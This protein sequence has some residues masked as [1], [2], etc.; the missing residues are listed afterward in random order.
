[1]KKIHISFAAIF[2]LF[3]FLIYAEKHP[4]GN[5]DNGVSKLKK[6]LRI[7]YAKTPP[8]ALQKVM[9]YIDARVKA[10]MPAE[11]C[12]KDFSITMDY[13]DVFYL[14]LFETVDSYCDGAAHPSSDQS[15]TLFDM[16]TGQ[17]IPLSS[18]IIKGTEEKLLNLLNKKLQKVLQEMK[19][20]LKES[21]DES[22]FSPYKTKLDKEDLSSLVLGRD[23]ILLATDFLSYADR[24]CESA[25]VLDLKEAA[26]YFRIA[27]NKK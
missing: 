22:S 19:Q 9:N 14:S 27:F 23:Q 11:G 18:L 25:L 7:K 3:V 1:M 16:T 20:C 15:T 24:S 2:S 26:P 8:A 6:E 10:N 21:G 5:N 4:N 12:S 17:I 13:A